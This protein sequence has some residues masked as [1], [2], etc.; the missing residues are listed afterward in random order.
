[1]SKGNENGPP[2]VVESRR[3]PTRG[4]GDRR[5]RRTYRIGLINREG[6]EQYRTLNHS[7]YVG[8]RVPP[9]NHSGSHNATLMKQFEENAIQSRSLRSNCGVDIVQFKARPERRSLESGAGG[10]ARGVVGG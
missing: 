8:L 2:S 1:M 7:R 10:G 9:L 3:P 4:C 6:N 5:R